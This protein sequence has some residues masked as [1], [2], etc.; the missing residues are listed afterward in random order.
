MSC[1]PIETLYSFCNEFKGC[2][3]KKCNPDYLCKT[4]NKATKRL[5]KFSLLDRSANSQKDDHQFQRPGTISC[6]YNL[7]L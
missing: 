1:Q 6:F 5:T 3:E 4:Q 7:I 2:N